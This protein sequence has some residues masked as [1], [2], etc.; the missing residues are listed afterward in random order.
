MVAL[1]SLSIIE[2]VG[3]D[4]ANAR[5]V[6]EAGNDDRVRSRIQ[7]GHQAASHEFVSQEN[8]PTLLPSAET[9]A[10]AVTHD[11]D[12]VFVRTMTRLLALSA[13]DGFVW[14]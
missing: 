8:A 12:A 4:N 14:P 1:S 7:S 9:M 5:G 3:Y 2:I 13:L 6:A 11:G 10:E